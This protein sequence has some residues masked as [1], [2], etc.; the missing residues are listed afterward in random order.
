MPSISSKGETVYIES[1]Q[2]ENGSEVGQQ[3]ERCIA[4]TRHLPFQCLQEENRQQAHEALVSSSFSAGSH[5]KALGAL[6]SQIAWRE[7]TAPAWEPGITHLPGGLWDTDLQE[8]VCGGR[9]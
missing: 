8:H 4:G 1:E 2:E 7:C 3:G 6:A 9:S 5:S